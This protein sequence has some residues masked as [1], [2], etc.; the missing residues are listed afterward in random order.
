LTLSCALF[1]NH[2]AALEAEDA[3]EEVEISILSDLYEPV[4]FDHAMHLDVADCS[5]CHHH[6]TGQPPE[7]ENCLKCHANSEETDSISCSECHT[8]KRFYPEDLEQR[9]GDIYHIDKP[10]LKGA[11]HLNCVGCHSE[12]DAPTGCQDCHALTPKGEQRLQ[13]SI[14]P[15]AKS[16][17]G[18][19][20]N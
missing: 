7:D 3:P 6:T 18:N 9:N 4:Y 15:P 11:Y 5:A 2:A 13:V 19:E 14:V 20:H 17:A 1:P 8:A 12:N 16:H 10:G